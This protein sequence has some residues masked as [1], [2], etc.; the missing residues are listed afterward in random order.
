[1]LEKLIDSKINLHSK[2]ISPV[3]RNIYIDKQLRL[4][5]NRIILG[6]YFETMTCG[7]YGGKLAIGLRLNGD[8][9]KDLEE[10]V[11]M[12]D[13]L[14]I[15]PDIIRID[16]TNKK[17]IA[18]GESKAFCGG[19]SCMI[20]KRQIEKYKDI[21]LRRQDSEI[22]Y[23]LYRHELY[24]FGAFKGADKELFEAL[25]DKTRFSLRMPFSIVWAFDRQETGEII[26][27]YDNES[28]PDHLFLSSSAINR[29]FENPVEVIE[30]MG[31]K[32]KDYK[33]ERLL[34]PSKFTIEG[35]EVKQFPI[36][37]I[38]DKNHSV[39]VKDFA[40]E[41]LASEGCSDR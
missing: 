23:A 14:C 31:L 30:K 10:N 3:H 2:E 38:K 35:Y 6:N 27:R 33:I 28:Y 36:I 4:F 18:I 39:W 24:E 21:Q 5:T 11:S 12:D 20:S 15:E 13:D 26:K 9:R 8:S 34:S 37:S 29:F 32:V 1:M 7:F 16:K 41:L 17:I 19:N 40:D 25:A 22:Y